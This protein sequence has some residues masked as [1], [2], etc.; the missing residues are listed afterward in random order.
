MGE[1]QQALVK[2]VQKGRWLKR[3]AEEIAD[4]ELMLGQMKYIFGIKAKDISEYKLK[5]IKRIKTRLNK[6]EKEK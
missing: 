6:K 5:K 1:L 3:V 2:Q 4:V